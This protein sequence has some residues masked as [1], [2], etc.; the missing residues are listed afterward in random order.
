VGPG[1]RPSRVI[2][3]LGVLIVLTVLGGAA[4]F[5]LTK[6]DAVL[7]DAR[8][9]A[10]NLSMAL[11]METSRSLE[12]IDLLVRQRIAAI[13]AADVSDAATFAAYASTLEINEALKTEAAR[14]PQVDLLSLVNADGKVLNFNRYWPIPEISLKDRDYYAAL[15]QGDTRQPYISAPV[16][17]RGTGTWTI[18]VARRVDGPNGAFLGLVLGGMRSK[19]L[20]D[21]YDG[22][23]LD[24]DSAIVVMRQDGVLLMRRPNVEGQIGRNLGG[25]LVFKALAQGGGRAGFA[26]DRSMVDG[27]LR[28]GSAR[29]LPEFPVIVAITRSKDAV[30]RAWWT[31]ARGVMAGGILLAVGVAVVIPL[32]F[33][34]ER[35]SETNAAALADSEASKRA[36]FESAIHGILTLD[37][38]GL[39]LEFNPAAERMF[40]RRREDVLGRVM[41]DLLV[42]ARQRRH[43][44][45]AL[46]A[47]IERRDPTMFNRVLRTEAMHANGTV[48]PIEVAISP[49]EFAGH[50]RF[51]AHVRDISARLETERQLLQREEQAIAAR[52]E[53]EASGRAKS[54]FLATMSHEIRTPL[55]GVI[56][57][58]GLL[59][60]TKLDETQNDYAHAIKGSA[61]HLLR[62]LCDILDFSKLDAGKMVLEETPFDLRQAISSAVGILAARAD[63]KGLSLEVAVGPDLPSRLLGDASRV[64]QIILNIVGNALK[65]TDTGGVW[66]RTYN[67]SEDADRVCLGIDVR[68][69]GIG[70]SAAA[71]AELFKEFSQVKGPGANRHGGTG[72]GLV[73]SQRLAISMGGGI[74]IESEP[75]VGSVFKI[76]LLLRRDLGV[77]PATAAATA[78]H[79]VSEIAEFAVAHF[80]RPLRVLLAEDNRTNQFVGVAMLKRMGCQ[81][82]VAANGFEATEILGARGYDI[83]LMDM[84]MPEMN[85]LEAT[86]VVRATDGPNQ[87]VPIVA[88][89][90]NAFSQD[91]R[92]C[93]DA[94][95][96]GFLAKPMTRDGLAEAILAALKGRTRHAA[97]EALAEIGGANTDRPCDYAEALTS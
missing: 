19:Y 34:R 78:A 75:G 52:A 80:G 87:L 35:R 29:A 89:T 45:R 3:A 46:R 38:H 44:V 26:E 22:L 47:W 77:E 41:V 53:A 23:S 67:I 14:L 24:A 4:L 88:V 10:D 12:A 66:I 15:A 6:R 55:N 39:L 69:T 65:F 2:A 82:D 96:S 70:I 59:L 33:R 54:D 86:R 79:S 37:E 94:G 92:D 71:R 16:R 83:V 91:R 31:E 76:R 63:A 20:A 27:V 93:L 5:L 84:R 51:V 60:D 18:Y 17:N 61:D 97:S 68:D 11:S 48:F 13:H 25:G 74:E 36:I 95:M 90:A 73:I 40:G 57:C 42:P 81:V 30:L 9:E 72:L 28:I 85:G 64:R 32:L 49:I 43:H 8:R 50:A 7:H 1:L 56:G 58:A 21:L 62:L